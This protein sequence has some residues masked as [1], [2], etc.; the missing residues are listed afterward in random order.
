[1]FFRSCKSNVIRESGRAEVR[2]SAES[3]RV[4][5]RLSAESGRAEV[6]HYTERRSAEVFHG[7]ESGRA[8]GRRRAESGRAE[9]CLS[10]KFKVLERQLP[11]EPYPAKVKIFFLKFSLKRSLEICALLFTWKVKHA[12]PLVFEFPI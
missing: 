3:G 12:V 7:A 1:M 11:G 9:V 5:V 6:R 4:E 2:L 8:E 10:C